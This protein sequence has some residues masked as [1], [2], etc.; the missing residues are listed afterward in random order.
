MDTVTQL[1]IPTLSGAGV[2][3]I[4]AL[5]N[6]YRQRVVF[7]EQLRAAV[8]ALQEIPKVYVRQDNFTLQMQII[9]QKL[10]SINKAME[11]ERKIDQLLKQAKG[12]RK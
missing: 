11:V 9:E 10:D 8:Q 2:A 4:V 6:N 5:F 3:L 12:G 1:M 7:G